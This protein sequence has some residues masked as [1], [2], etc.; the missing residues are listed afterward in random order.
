[1]TIQIPEPR[2]A[3]VELMGH[4][5]RA[6]A[7]SDAT[8]GGATLLR[9]EHP[10]LADHT[11]EE[12]LTEYYAPSAI[13]AIHPCSHEQAIEA[14]KYWRPMPSGPPALSAGF[15]DLIED[16]LDDDNRV[17]RVCGCTEMDACTGGCSWVDD[18]QRLGDLCSSCLPAAEHAAE[19][20]S[21]DG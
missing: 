4:R 5:T 1:M 21:A 10:A 12:P 18:P 15:D 8:I 13:F 2:W 9:I 16:D 6:G 17:C 19:F 20:A 7:I 3:V 11:G 14:A